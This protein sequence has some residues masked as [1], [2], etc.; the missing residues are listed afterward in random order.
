M[1]LIFDAE[2][3][4]LRCWLPNTSLNYF[5]WLTDV[6]WRDKTNWDNIIGQ[7][8]MLEFFHQSYVSVIWKLQISV[9]MILRMRQRSFHPFLGSSSLSQMS[10]MTSSFIPF[11]LITGY[12]TDAW[13]L[14]LHCF[15][16]LWIRIC[17]KCGFLPGKHVIVFLDIIGGFV[18][19]VIAIWFLQKKLLSVQCNKNGQWSHRTVFHTFF[20]LSFFWLLASWS[21]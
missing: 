16:P 2:Q 21:K 8:I 10:D 1:H 13:G 6:G 18:L 12:F 14:T 20:S 11:L 9:D 19:I 17:S 4:D 7:L 5:Q 15:A 3:Q